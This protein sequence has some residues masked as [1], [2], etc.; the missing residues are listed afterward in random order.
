MMSLNTIPTTTKEEQRRDELAQE[1]GE[2]NIF[3]L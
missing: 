1:D 3:V 2:L